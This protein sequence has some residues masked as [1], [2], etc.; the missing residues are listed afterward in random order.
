M[1]RQHRCPGCG[2]T[3]IGDAIAEDTCLSCLY[4]LSPDGEYVPSALHPDA[5]QRNAE[6]APGFDA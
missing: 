4:D 3:W 5:Q 1:T 6:A 2:H